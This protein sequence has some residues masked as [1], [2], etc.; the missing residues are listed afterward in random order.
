MQHPYALSSLAPG[1]NMC[2]RKAC[3]V[4]NLFITVIG[5]QM[6]LH[7]CPSVLTLLAVTLVLLEM[8]KVYNIH[9][10]V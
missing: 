7:D 3:S 1:C 5:D 8:N 9:S 6:A 10:W 4:N 2:I